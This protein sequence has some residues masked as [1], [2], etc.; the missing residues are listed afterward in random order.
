MIEGIK[1]VLP[2]KPVYVID[3]MNQLDLK[4]KNRPI[5]INHLCSTGTTVNGC[6][7]MGK[8]TNL[9]SNIFCPIYI[10]QTHIFTNF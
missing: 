2:S 9:L 7:T 6:K 10:G 5:T 3:D 4:Q 1:Q 8:H